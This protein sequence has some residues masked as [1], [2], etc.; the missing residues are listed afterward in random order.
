MKTFT[1]PS[2]MADLEQA[3]GQYVLYR[4]FLKQTEPT[5]ELYLAV[6]QDTVE[7]LFRMAIGRGFL[8]DER[9]KVLGYD[10]DTE[11]MREWLP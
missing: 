5:R 1:G 4:I 8:E 3:L 10:G 9:G 2:R 11:E 6:P 7:D